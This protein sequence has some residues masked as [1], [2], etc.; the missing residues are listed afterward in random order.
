MGYSAEQYCMMERSS[1]S[2]TTTEEDHAVLWE[3]RKVGKNRTVEWKV[4]KM[5]TVESVY[6]GHLLAAF[7]SPFS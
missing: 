2:S 1:S 7:P 4:W 6:A 3:E 5:P